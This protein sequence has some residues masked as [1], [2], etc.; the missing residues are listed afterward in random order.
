M[1]RGFTVLFL[2]EIILIR[3]GVDKRVFS[4]REKEQNREKERG[5]E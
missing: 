4:W 2:F 5:T 1:K 3:K